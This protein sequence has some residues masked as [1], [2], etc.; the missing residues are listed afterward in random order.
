MTI[1]NIN[2]RRGPLPHKS[3]APGY[4]IPAAEQNLSRFDLDAWMQPDQGNVLASAP[5]L[6]ILSRVG[7]YDMRTTGPSTTIGTGLTDDLEVVQFAGNQQSGSTPLVVEGLRLGG[8]Y[9]LAGIFHIDAA[10][11]MGNTFT[12]FAAGVNNTASSLHIFQQ[13]GVLR[14]RHGPQGQDEASI[15]EFS[16]GDT[17]LLMVCYEAAT[18]TIKA[19]INSLTPV[20]WE[21]T[22]ATGAVGGDKDLRIGG[23]WN[24][25]QN[26]TVQQLNGFC[27]AAW[28]AKA[29]WGRADYD[30]IREAFM[31]EVAAIYADDITLV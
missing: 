26:S 15:S 7:A 30:E 25:A 27:R 4:A 9:M 29:P 19:Y 23:Q 21:A 1:G 3:L 24:T 14:V 11:N 13:T 20:T 5:N 28:V 18:D 16:A 17:F 10:A 6:H 12:F 8:D 22:L 31:T 2:F